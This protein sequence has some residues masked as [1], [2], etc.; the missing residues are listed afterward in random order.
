MIDPWDG[1]EG[2]THYF[3]DGCEPPHGGFATAFDN[4]D[5]STSQP[6]LTREVF[7]EAMRT[8]AEATRQHP[9]PMTW[10]GRRETMYDLLFDLGAARAEDGFTPMPVALGALRIDLIED[11][12]VIE[13]MVI[14]CGPDRTILRAFVQAQD[15]QW[16][17]I[18]GHYV[19]P[20]LAWTQ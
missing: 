12:D 10:H 1:P 7:E 16:Y 13:S 8:V 4:G 3:G 15:D 11:P 18:D 6:E 20:P 9:M 14:E 17:V 2:Q 19:L 5:W